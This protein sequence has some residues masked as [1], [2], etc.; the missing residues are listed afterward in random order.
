MVNV[1]TKRL[2]FEF[3]IERVNELDAIAD[4]TGLK[5]RVQLFNSALTLFEWAVREREAGRII[6]AID[7]QT[8]QYKE[9]DMPG[10]PKVERQ[11]REK[12]IRDFTL[13]AQLFGVVNKVVREEADPAQRAVVNVNQ[14]RALD[15]LRSLPSDQREVLMLR[16]LEDNT[17]EEIAQVL[18]KS[19]SSIHILQYRALKTL[20]QQLAAQGP[21]I[22]PLDHGTAPTASTPLSQTKHS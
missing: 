8:G 21:L 20:R 10:L 12:G 18:G 2:Q 17:E 4:E 3:P 13:A 11:E 14:E 1:I 7:E 16:Y 5:T 6:A 19:T 15:A 9:F 22:A